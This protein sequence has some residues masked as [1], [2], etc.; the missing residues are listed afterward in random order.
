MK[1]KIIFALVFAIASISVFAQEK[2]GKKQT[3]DHVILY[4][5]ACPMHP[6]FVSEKPGK[7]PKC[8]MNF[9]QL[10]A[11]EQLK[12]DVTKT[13]T[14]TTDAGVISTQPGK[15]PKCGKDLNLSVKEK[16]KTDV[17]EY[18]CP[19]HPDQT[20]NEPGKCAKCGMD[21]VEKKKGKS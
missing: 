3:A 5:Y 20:S 7:C 6:N 4:S 2:A 21:L 11:K 17:V 18:Y 19:M 13:Y 1:K 10:S 16:I 15:C 8:G 12:G 9:T 14:C